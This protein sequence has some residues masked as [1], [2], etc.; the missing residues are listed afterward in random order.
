MGTDIWPLFGCLLYEFLFDYG[1]HLHTYGT[2]TLHVFACMCFPVAQGQI[3]GIQL[4]LTWFYACSGWCKIGPWFKYLNVSNLMTAKFMV[5][6]P[7]AGLYRR[8]MFKAPE[9]DD[10][11][12]NLTCC[13]S[14][15]STICALLETLGPALCLFSSNEKLISLGIVLFICM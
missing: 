4:F 13:A 9:A 10:P 15:F 3:V 1:Q 12:Y 2:Q 7:W 6:T 5:G 8:L 11:D 14:I